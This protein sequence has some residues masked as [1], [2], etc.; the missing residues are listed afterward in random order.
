MNSKIQ[1][2]N[3]QKRLNKITPYN[4]DNAMRKLFPAKRDYLLR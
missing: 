1:H 3:D 4:T 2:D